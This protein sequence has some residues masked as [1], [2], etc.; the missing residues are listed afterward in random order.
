MSAKVPTLSTSGWVEDIA[1]KADR[2]MS[3]YFVSDASQTTL[4]L[5]KITSLPLQIQRYGQDDYGLRQAVQAE[6]TQLFGRYF[7]AVQVE[8]TTDKPVPND[9]NRINLTLSVLVTQNGKQYSLGRLISTINSKITQIVDIN[10]N[11]GA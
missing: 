9:L 11:Q 2:L 5:G 3:Y 6:L 7:D 1:E 8:V 10:N 4:Y